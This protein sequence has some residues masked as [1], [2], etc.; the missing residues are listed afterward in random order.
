M[1]FPPA[2]TPDLCPWTSVSPAVQRKGESRSPF[3]QL[4]E[5]RGKRP[6][7]PEEGRPETR[8]RRGLAE[9]QDPQASGLLS[10]VLKPHPPWEPQPVGERRG[11]HRPCAP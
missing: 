10:V 8:G 7:T 11:A 3:S 5:S 6:P 4:W 1:D 2:S 9:G